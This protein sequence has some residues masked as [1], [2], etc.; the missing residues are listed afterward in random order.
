[1]PGSSLPKNSRSVTLAPTRNDGQSRSDYLR[2]KYLEQQNLRA[3]RAVSN[4]RGFNPRRSYNANRAIQGRNE[5]YQENPDF[6]PLG[7]NR[8]NLPSFQYQGGRGNPKGSYLNRANDGAQ[9]QGATELNQSLTQMATVSQQLNSA[10]DKLASLP[11]LEITINGKIAPVEVVLN[12][13]QM[14]AEFKETFMNEV[15]LMVGNAII[16][17]NTSLTNPVV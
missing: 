11:A 12:G 17:Q 9:I 5:R 8:G 2:N 6:S 14:L 13:T 16:A 15:R 1:M 7:T 10:A 4:R 3:N